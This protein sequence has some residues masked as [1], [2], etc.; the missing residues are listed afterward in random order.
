MLFGGLDVNWYVCLRNA[1]RYLVNRF[2]NFVWFLMINCFINHAP[3]SK[4]HVHISFWLDL[5]DVEVNRVLVGIVVRPASLI[6]RLILWTINC[7]SPWYILIVRLM[8]V[9]V[10]AAWASEL[11][12]III[13]CLLSDLLLYELLLYIVR[14]WGIL[15]SL[16]FLLPCPRFLGILTDNLSSCVDIEVE[17]FHDSSVELYYKNI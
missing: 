7:M 15:L 16:P 13:C 10:P 6:E 3:R 5:S 2:Y 17:M 8:L 4:H 1:L 11:S 9:E 12:R 14:H